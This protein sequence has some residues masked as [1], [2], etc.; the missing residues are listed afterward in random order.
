MR[1]TTVLGALA[2]FAGLLMLAVPA[3]AAPVPT[4]FSS[5]AVQAS[6]TGQ[7]T[8]PA[9]LS[10]PGDLLIVVVVSTGNPFPPFPAVGDTYGAIGTGLGSFNSVFINPPGPGQLQINVFTAISKAP[11]VASPDYVRVTMQPGGATNFQVAVIDVTGSTAPIANDII[12]T[13]AG[14]SGSPVALTS[15]PVFNSPTLLVAAVAAVG[16]STIQPLGTASALNT[17]SNT[18]ST[19]ATMSQNDPAATPMTVTASLSPSA[20][21]IGALITIP[22]QGTGGGWTQTQT[23]VT[24]IGG[25]LLGGGLLVGFAM[26]GLKAIPI[27]AIILVLVIVAGI[28]LLVSG[29]TGFIH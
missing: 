8:T 9:V 19:L 14:V 22:A 20:L 15:T 13:P 6:G 25:I 12:T 11:S 23:L 24:V 26:P 21:W 28:V 4:V 5:V 2:V 18:N 10:S 17:A 27:A 7:I 3:S 1:K 29:V 16:Q